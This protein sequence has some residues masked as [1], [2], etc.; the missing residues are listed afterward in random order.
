VLSFVAIHD[1][2]ARRRVLEYCL[3]LAAYLVAGRKFLHNR[4]KFSDFVLIG[5][6]GRPRKGKDAT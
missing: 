6:H 3:V 4:P 2:N 5:K 1:T